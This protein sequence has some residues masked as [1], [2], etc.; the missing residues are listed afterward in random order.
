MMIHNTGIIN[1]AD[2]IFGQESLI[3][4]RNPV[5][6]GLIF[7][8]KLLDFCIPIVSGIYPPIY[9]VGQYGSNK[10]GECFLGVMW[11]QHIQS[12]QDGEVKDMVDSFIEERLQ[13]FIRLLLEFYQVLCDFIPLVDEVI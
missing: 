5:F 3:L 8:M 10:A 12:L 7:N 4:C 6:K 13:K 11:L 9:P 1:W 2:C